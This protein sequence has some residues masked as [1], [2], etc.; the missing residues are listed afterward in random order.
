MGWKILCFI[1]GASSVT[2]SW[3]LSDYSPLMSGEYS[4]SHQMW[5]TDDV[6]VRKHAKTT[7]ITSFCQITYIKICIFC[8]TSISIFFLQWGWLHYIQLYSYNWTNYFRHFPDLSKKLVIAFLSHLYLLNNW[9]FVKFTW[10]NYLSSNFPANESISSFVS[11]I[12]CHV[13]PFIDRFKGN[14]CLR[15]KDSVH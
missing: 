7:E 15:Y 5:V 6:R 12:Y 10:F 1:R 4:E 11:F 13:N 8:R 2:H 9:L 14:G 3:S